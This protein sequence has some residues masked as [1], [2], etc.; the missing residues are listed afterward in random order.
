MVMADCGKE[1]GDVMV[2]QRIDD[3]TTLAAGAHEPQ[4]AQDAEMV[5]GR[6]R[7]EPGVLGELL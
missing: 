6:A 2:M 1:F 3:V 4:R 5:R 7:P